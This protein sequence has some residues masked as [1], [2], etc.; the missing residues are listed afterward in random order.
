MNRKIK[1][2]LS[3][4]NKSKIVSLTA[5][6]KSIAKILDKHIDIV[7]VGDSMANVL[8]GHENTHKITLDNI[9]QHS[10]SVKKGI[11]KSLLVVDMPKGSYN[12]IK[13]AV[14]NVKKVINKTGCD[15]IKLESNKKNYKIIETLVKKKIPI[16]G[17]IGY[18]PQYKKKFKVEGQTKIET[19]KLLKEAKLIEKAGAFSIVLECISSISAKIITS[20]LNIPTIGIGS[21]S[22]C[23]GQILVTDDMLGI[24]GFYP[25]F[26]KKYANLDRIIEK[27]VK[28]YTREVKLK[29][30]PTFKN[31]L[32]GTKLRK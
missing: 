14:K 27:A 11:K 9:I 12:N 24:S 18:T 23:D 25:K 29:K 21:S 5:Y 15:A 31:F 17:H 7:L 32:H 1:N 19:K 22:Y 8:Y 16:M 30:F 13:S 10:L 3:K 28:K 4:K 20:K 6:S 26:V 2:I